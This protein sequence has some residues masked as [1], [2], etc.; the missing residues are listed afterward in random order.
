MKAK[1]RIKDI[2]QE[3]RDM[4]EQ[5]KDAYLEQIHKHDF[6]QL[7]CI[8]TMRA[9]CAAFLAADDQDCMTKDEI[10]RFVEGMIEIMS[11]ESFDFIG[12]KEMAKSGCD[13]VTDSMLIEMASRGMYV[14]FRGV[15]NYQSVN[16]IADR[17]GER[18]EWNKKEDV[19][20]YVFSD[21]EERG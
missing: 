4:W 1:I 12:R 8:L 2:P 18:F 21:D 5:E 15:Q 9:I 6:D 13:P 16:V 19:N 17:L 11:G 3:K 20:E 10:K 7:Q 14:R